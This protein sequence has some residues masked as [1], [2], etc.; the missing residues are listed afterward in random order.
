MHSDAANKSHISTHTDSAMPSLIGV[1]GPSRR[2]AAQQPQCIEKS[3]APSHST[4]AKYCK[5]VG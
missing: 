4:K 3:V 2:L 1:L 5:N